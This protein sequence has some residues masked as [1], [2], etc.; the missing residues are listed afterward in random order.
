MNYLDTDKYLVLV[1]LTD[2]AETHA[3]LAIIHYLNNIFTEKESAMAAS[4]ITDDA[5]AINNVDSKEEA[6]NIVE[7]LKRFWLKDFNIPS[8]ERFSIIH[9]CCNVE[10]VI[11]NV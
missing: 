1:E 2:D 10:E 7:F 5:F 4:F 6:H 3:L 9:F 8:I 11:E